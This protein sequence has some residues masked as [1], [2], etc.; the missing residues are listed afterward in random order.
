MTEAFRGNS[1]IPYSSI[2]Q[3]KDLADPIVAMQALVLRAGKVVWRRPLGTLLYE[4]VC[5]ALG[6]RMSDAALRVTLTSVTPQDVAMIVARTSGTAGFPKAM[7]THYSIVNQW[8][9]PPGSARLLTGAM[10]P[11][12]LFAYRP[13]PAIASIAGG[14]DLDSAHR[15]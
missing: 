4:R 9:T 11:M 7:L 8:R 15:L 5:T 2:V 13:G 1:W 6:Q 3:M 10:N 14:A 12:P